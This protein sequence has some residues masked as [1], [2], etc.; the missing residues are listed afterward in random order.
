[1][2]YR[3]AEQVAGGE[4]V[5]GHLPSFATENNLQLG[6][7]QVRATGGK[8]GGLQHLPAAMQLAVGLVPERLGA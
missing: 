4:M 1:V 7:I 6:S 2:A 8:G 3:P 5:H